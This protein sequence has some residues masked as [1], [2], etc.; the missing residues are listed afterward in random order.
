MTFGAHNLVHFQPFFG[1]P[2]RTLTTAVCAI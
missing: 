1:L 2:I